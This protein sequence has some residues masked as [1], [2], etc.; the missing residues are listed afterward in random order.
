MS[1]AAYAILIHMN[2]IGTHTA[3]N[4]RVHRVA[5]DLSQVQLSERAGLAK[6]AVG[7]LERGDH[8][9]TLVTL[10]KIASA[11]GV[12]A[13]ELVAAETTVRARKQEI[14]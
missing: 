11:L 14:K 5:A 6:D 9:P 8:S 1:I 7:R 10:G 3:R 2:E 4:V 12:T 13:E